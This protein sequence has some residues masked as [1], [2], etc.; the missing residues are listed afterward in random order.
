MVG[1]STE[2]RTSCLAQFNALG[3]GHSLTPLHSLPSKGGD[4]L[5]VAAN[6]PV[7]DPHQV[8]PLR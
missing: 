3:K 6:R 4:S 7:L 5:A 1:G 2:T 8:A